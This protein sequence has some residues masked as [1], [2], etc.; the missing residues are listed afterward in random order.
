MTSESAANPESPKGMPL[1]I[2]GMYIFIASELILF[3][4][5]LFILFWLRSGRESEWPPPG[6]PRLP[7][8]ITGINTV[9]LLGS[10][11]TMFRAYRSIKRDLRQ[12]LTRWL[13]MTCLLGAVFLTVQ[14]FEWIRLIRFG[15][16]MQSSLY[17][18]MFY[19]IIGL[20]ALHV[21]GTVMVLLYLWVRS[22]T[23]FYTMEKHTGVVLGYMFW[24]FV[25]LIWPVLYGLVYMT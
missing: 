12:D 4:T 1:E 10:G 15:L 16:T 3:A 13:M 24:L 21:F 11:Y 23:G 19:L 18:A 22:T 20:H 17:G 9:I 14:G 8:G 25:V 7:L 5:L 2:L 6:Q